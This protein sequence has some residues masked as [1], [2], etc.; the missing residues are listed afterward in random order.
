[1]ASNIEIQP[2]LPEDTI[3]L[4]KVHYRTFKHSIVPFL[5][6]AE[7]SEESYRFLA[8]E[9]TRILGQPHTKAFKAIDI[10]T[11]EL[12][13]AV[14]YK[15]MAEGAKQSDLD[16]GIPVF[17]SF[18]QEQIPEAWRALSIRLGQC[19]ARHVGTKPCVEVWLMIVD[20]A[21]QG[22]GI[23][24]MLLEWGCQEADR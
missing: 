9:R 8:S 20:P 21:H 4:V 15:V 11:G 2:L 12:V 19:Y 17:D 7:P 10:T 16:N 18:V 24:K 5:F 13:G 3:M 14:Y 22:K 6:N 1:M 23:G